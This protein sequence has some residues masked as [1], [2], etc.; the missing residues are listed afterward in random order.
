MLEQLLA[1]WELVVLV[2]LVLDKIV[3]MTPCKWDDLILT[4]I[5][6]ALGKVA[7]KS[8]TWLLLVG[9]LAAFSAATTGCAL[10]NISDAP[11]HD[12]ARAYV[13]LLIDTHDG[14]RAAYMAEWHAAGPER[15]AW[16]GR[17]VGIPLNAAYDAIV[18]AGLA[19]E[20]WSRAFDNGAATEA[21]EVRFKRLLVKAQEAVDRV[22]NLWLT[23]QKIIKDGE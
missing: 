12:Q 9:C 23:A 14:V 15:K 1:N 8:L 20:E 13:D 4:A 5:K 16:L 3:A 11:P 21:E 6:G 22:K 10:N 19:A 2:V 7:G 17:D 18:L